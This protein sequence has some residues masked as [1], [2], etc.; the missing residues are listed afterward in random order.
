MKPFNFRKVNEP[1]PTEYLQ[2]MDK[3]EEDN[4]RENHFCKPTCTFSDNLSGWL[5][6]QSD[7][8]SEA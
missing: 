5:C 1:S 3:R 4:K 6:V 7:H 2:T 8:L